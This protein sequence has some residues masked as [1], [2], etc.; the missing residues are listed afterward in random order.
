MDMKFNMAYT[1]VAFAILFFLVTFGFIMD[2]IKN[3]KL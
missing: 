3:V 1:R 2:R